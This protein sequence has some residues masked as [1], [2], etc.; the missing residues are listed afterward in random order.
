VPERVMPERSTHPVLFLFMFVPMGISNGYVV[1]TLAYL[2]AT[3]GVTVDAIAMLG[4]WS[5]VPQLGKFLVGPLV[6]TTLT[7]KAWYLLATVATGILIAVTGFVP[8][9][10]TDL[11]LITVFVF[12]ISV[13]SA[14]SALAA[15]TIM[16]HATKPEEKG[17]AGGWS[18]AGNLGGSAIGG[19][20][21]LWVAQTMTPAGSAAAGTWLTRH[22]G[23]TWF[24]EAGHWLGTHLDAAVAGSL[25]VGLLCVVTCAAVAYVHEPA[26]ET[27]AGNF[28]KNII[29]VGRDLWALMKSRRGLV[30]FVA[31]WL[32]IS[33]AAMTQLWSAVAPDWHASAGTVATINGL[34]GGIINIVGCIAGG[35]IADR[36]NRMLAFNITSLLCAG[37]A[38]AAALSPRTETTY[39]IYVGLY[40]L[41]AGFCYATWA[42]VVLEAI[43][44]GA[45]ATKYNVL[46][47]IA[48]FPIIYLSWLDGQ[49]HNVWKVPSWLPVDGTQ[50]MLLTDALIPVA[51]TAVLVAFI[52]LTRRYYKNEPAGSTG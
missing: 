35:W 11:G 12:F 50:L 52:V 48:N 16:A 9:T 27:R 38:L 14:F 20:L 8:A 45:A 43:G 6:D 10:A 4:V 32:P 42:A 23:L 18:Q 46:A 24:T 39:M 37:V 30:A 15:D 31:M 33:T 29:S 44:V 17:R 13:A 25:S 36:M 40:M 1:V 2:L 26:S 3:G 28:V 19:G 22:S 34:L 47:G 7:A 49:A 51:G 5:L 21:G 41:I